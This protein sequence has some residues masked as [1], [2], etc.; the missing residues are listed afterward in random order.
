MTALVLLA[1]A[2]AVGS[3]PFGLW[4]AR[5]QGVDL[6]SSGSRNVGATN[7]L[8]T[9]GRLFAAIVLVLDAAK[10]AV[11]MVVARIVV[12][13]PWLIAGCAVAVVVGHVWP[14]WAGLRGGKGVATLAGA[15]AVLSPVAA[16]WSGVMFV[17]VV[18]M[19]RYVSLAS[20]VAAATLSLGTLLFDGRPSTTAAAFVL[21]VLV[22]WRHGSNIAR[23]I[24]GSESRVGERIVTGRRRGPFVA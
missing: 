8:R 9:L 17:C 6:R 5:T 18:A 7:V 12:D 15:Y 11:A 22:I 14:M 24:D 10:G 20:I 19:S 2:Y 16:L 4:L 21:A 23:L 3:L 13:D 1:G